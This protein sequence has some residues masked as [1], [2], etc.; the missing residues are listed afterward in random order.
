MQIFVASTNTETP[1][2]LSALGIDWKLLIVQGAAF[3]VL[4]WIL[5][6]FVYPVL[7]K[8]I[9]DRRE[10]IESG[11]KEAKEAQAALADGERRVAEMLKDARKEAD[12]IIKQSQQ[13]SAV[14][15]NEAEDKAKVRA[16]RIVK[17]ART[18]LDVDVQNARRAL[19]SET[20][21]LV[22]QAT[23]KI[24]GSKLDQAKDAGLIERALKERA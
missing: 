18:Q 17:D 4:V 13:E 15:V 12:A 2:L 19:K 14:L 9:D 1:S 24:I 20:I 5:G 11:L 22:A 8:S 16:E 7:I 23:E 3:L 10:A 6:K 21:K